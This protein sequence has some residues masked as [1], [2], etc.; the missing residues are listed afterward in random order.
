MGSGVAHHVLCPYKHQQNGLAEGKHHHTVEVGLSLLAQAYMQLEFWDDSF[1]AIIY[2]I[3]RT[4]S[5]VINY[6]IVGT[7][8]S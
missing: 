7:L 8:V 5:K 6:E 2:L 3:S 1:L 4:P